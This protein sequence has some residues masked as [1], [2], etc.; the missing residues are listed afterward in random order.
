MQVQ[1]R[2]GTVRLRS[3]DPQDTPLIDFN[4]FAQGGDHDLQALSEGIEI[5]QR[6]FN[7]T[8]A[9]YGPFTQI[10][11]IP[12][13]DVR[14][15]L[16]DE[17][18]SHHASS[19]CAIGPVNGTGT[20]VDSRFRVQGVEGLRVVDA[21]VFPRVPGAFPILPT[22]MVSEKATDVILEDNA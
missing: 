19:S 17:T 12:G 10:E 5:A 11:P 20:C 1:N 2:A 22:F 15:A 18:F 21:S 4:F 13:R 16:R 9:P 14:Q 6:I 8:G 7:S 3:A